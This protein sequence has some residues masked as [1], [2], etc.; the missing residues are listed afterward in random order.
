MASCGSVRASPLCRCIAP[1]LMGK[2]LCRGLTK[3][4]ISK[5]PALGPWTAA[6]VMVAYDLMEVDSQDV[7]PALLRAAL[8]GS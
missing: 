1:C 6:A 8:P 3:P 7:C 2:P 5:A 4:Q